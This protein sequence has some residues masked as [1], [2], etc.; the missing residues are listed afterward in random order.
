MYEDRTQ[1]N[2]LNELLEMIPENT[3]KYEGTIIYESAAAAAQ[4]MADAYMELEQFHNNMHASSCD[5]DSL[6]EKAKERN[7]FPYEATYAEY[8]GITNCDME[9]GDRFTKGDFIF[10]ITERIGDNTYRFR[11]ETEG[12]QCNNCYGEFDSLLDYNENY[13]SGELIELLVPARDYEEIEDFRERYFAD[14]QS[15]EFAGNIAAYVNEISAI[16]GV[17]HCKP[18]PRT[19][20][21]GQIKCIIISADWDVPSEL[22]VK[23][24]QDQV[25]PETDINNWGKEFGLPELTTYKGMGY[26]L[27][28]INHSVL[29]EGVKGVEIN[30][31]TKMEF[32]NGYS[33][34]QLEGSIEETVDKYFSELS[35]KWKKNS[36]VIVRRSH[37]DAELLNIE[38]ILDIHDTRINGDEVIALEIDQIPKRGAVIVE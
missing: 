38:G 28:P 27:A 21:G 35:E 32:D 37:I 16:E 33:F 36:Q 6:K 25:D 23:S 10:Q 18:I 7:L 8:K 26:G 3:S 2:I 17:G 30:I 31:T 15:K 19:I 5:Y 20:N 11:S 13:E 22:L 1:E 9:I 29:I 34:E 12:T 4:K 24:V 14:V